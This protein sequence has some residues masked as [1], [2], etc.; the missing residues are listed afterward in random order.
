MQTTLS[1]QIHLV[2][3]YGLI[4]LHNYFHL[5]ITYTI[6]FNQPF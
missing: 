6:L 1:V 5:L 2:H 4:L 3:H